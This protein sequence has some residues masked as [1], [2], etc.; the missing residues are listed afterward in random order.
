MSTAVAVSKPLP[1]YVSFE[2]LVNFLGDLNKTVV[3]SHI[4]KSIMGSMSGAT[5]SHLMSCLRSLGLVDASGMTSVPLHELVHAH[6]TPAWE[7]KFADVISPY[8][9]PLLGPLD[10]RTATAKQVRERFKDEGGMEGSM[11]DRA[12]RFFIRSLEEAKIPFSPHLKARKMRTTRKPG[13]ATRNSPDPKGV[14]SGSNGNSNRTLVSL[15]SPS[16]GLIRYPLHFRRQVDGAPTI[17]E[18]AIFVPEDTT[19]SDCSLIEAQ[20]AV[21]RIYA[22]AASK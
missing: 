1:P 12:I 10:V 6:G 3:P 7:Q 22:G 20:L 8:Y 13:S 2:T 19:E 9:A 5:Q 4:D 14:V 21:I 18:G 16:T 11:A 15:D 17:L